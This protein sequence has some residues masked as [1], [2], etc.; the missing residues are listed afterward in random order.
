MNRPG[1]DHPSAR[2]DSQLLEMEHITKEYPGVRALDDVSFDLRSGEVHCLLGENGAGKSTLIKILGGAVHADAGTIAVGGRPVELDSPADAQ[3]AGIGIIH[4]DFRLVPHLSV[5][6]NVLLGR[7]PIGRFGRVNWT[8]AGHRARELLQGLG[9]DVDVERRA[10]TL[11]V[12]QQQMVEISRVL[13]MDVRIIAMDEPSATL[14]DRELGRLFDIIGRLQESGVGII[15]ISHRLEEVAEIGDRATILRDGRRVHTGPVAA[16][17][18]AAIV[19]HMVGREVRE[20]RVAVARRPGR[21]ILEVEDLRREPAVR[22]VTFDVK[23]GEI[24]CLAGLVGA[25]RTETARLIFGAD[26]RDGGRIV[27]NQEEVEPRSPRHAISLGIGL[28]T[29]DRNRQGLI[30]E[31]MVRD[32]VVLSSLDRLRRGLRMDWD[33]AD[34][35]TRGYIS[36]LR[37]RTSGP[38]Q[39]VVDLSGGNRQK[40]IL[41]R[42]LFTHASVL[43]FDEP[44]WGIDVGAKQEIY[45]LLDELVEQ[46]VGIVVISSDLPEVLRL[47]D[48]IGVMRAGTLVGILNRDEAT[49]ERIMTLATGGD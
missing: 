26:S 39:R 27:L 44:T 7:L 43:L 12:A 19:R 35:I 23:E 42:W 29:E 21:V 46:G 33:R 49:Q 3:Q 1:T 40:V 30:L 41:A 11:S 2:P 4:Q 47:G 48:R 28:L 38:H 32:N 20:D 37:I 15:Y 14:T 34:E 9:E 5:T 18:R 16:L 45:A 8:A 6:E 36:S 31:M 25:G 13:N 17:D 22:G 10:G 24:F